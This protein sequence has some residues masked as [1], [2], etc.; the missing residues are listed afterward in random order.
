MDFVEIMNTYF[1]GEKIESAFFVV[2][3]GL[4]LW[5]MAF[6][7]WRTEQGGFMWG[8]FVPSVLMGLVYVGAGIAVAARTGDQVAA[9]EAGFG[10]DAAAMLSEEVPRMQQVVQNFHVALVIFGV[11]G[12]SGLVFRFAVPTDWAIGLGAVLVLV[13]GV[14]LLVD[15]FAERRSRPYM[16]ALEAL[17]LE[18]GVASQPTGD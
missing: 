4:L 3:V 18:H 2:P 8:V 5:A 11:I 1:R 7:A 16:A 15:G 10:S 14:G 17:A 6:G 9:L 13:S 12:V